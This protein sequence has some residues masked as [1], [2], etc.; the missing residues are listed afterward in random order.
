MYAIF[1]ILLFIMLILT[2]PVKAKGALKFDFK[3]KKGSLNVKIFFIP[4]IN[5][6]IIYKNYQ[7]EL[8]KH[9]SHKKINVPINRKNVL[10]ADNL[11][12]EIFKRIYLKK[13][14]CSI[15]LGI[16]NSPFFSALLMGLIKTF[17]SITYSVITFQKPTSKLMY[18][19]NT[20]YT[21]N[22]GIVNAEISCTLSIINFIIAYIKAKNCVNKKINGGEQNAI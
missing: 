22:L 18:S 6:D 19:L 16:R 17:F 10:L 2:F 5:Y 1:F 7:I 8:D 15:D 3:T 20:Y 13:L 12:K 9:K 4:I 11:R 21:K 14:D